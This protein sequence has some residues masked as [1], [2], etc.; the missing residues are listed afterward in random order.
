[1]III[2]S[3][4][5]IYMAYCRQL[6]TVYGSEIVVCVRCTQHCEKWRNVCA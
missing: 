5:D 3:Y 2:C 4:M 1:M 6:G